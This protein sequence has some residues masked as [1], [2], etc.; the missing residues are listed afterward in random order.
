MGDKVLENIMRSIEAQAAKEV[1]D[2][3]ESIDK[4]IISLKNDLT[5][6]KDIFIKEKEKEFKN[7]GELS[8][9]GLITDKKLQLKKELINKKRELIESIFD[10]I[11]EKLK[12]LDVSSKKILYENILKITVS[13]GDET[14]NPSVNEKTFDN[15]YIEAINKR[16]KWDLKL[17][18][19]E[20]ELNDGFLLREKD[21]VITVD[22]ENIRDFLRQREEG[23]VIKILFSN[24]DG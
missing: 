24:K 18:K 20:E 19:V 1:S 3:K 2:I 17:G 4:N 21:Y 9:R 15:A 23:N 7:E 14:I 16:N 13:A 22:W 8:K 5:K 11:I 10:D 12:K 6:K